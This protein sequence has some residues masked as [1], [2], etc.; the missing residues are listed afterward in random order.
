MWICGERP[1]RS[2]ILFGRWNKD[3]GLIGEK[4]M[5]GATKIHSWDATL[6]WYE[7]LQISLHMI[8]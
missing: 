4:H 7:Q 1:Q 8:W 3:G 6:I 5:I 2:R